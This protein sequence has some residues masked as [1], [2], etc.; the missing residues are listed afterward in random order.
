[1]SDEQ[2]ERTV[3]F[4]RNLELFNTRRWHDFWVENVQG[5]LDP[6]PEEEGIEMKELSD[7]VKEIRLSD[8]GKNGGKE[9]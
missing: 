1:M 3:S 4:R 8:V 7:D 6:L 2:Q 9:D 5:V